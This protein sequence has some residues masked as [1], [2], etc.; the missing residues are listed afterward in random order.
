MKKVVAGL[1][2]GFAL[3]VMILVT[4]YND[5]KAQKPSLVNEN[6]AEQQISLSKKSDKPEWNWDSNEMLA[7]SVHLDGHHDIKEAL[8]EKKQSQIVNKL[9]E[10]DSEIARLFLALDDVKV[11]DTLD[12]QS[13]EALNERLS[14]FYMDHDIVNRINNG[15][16]NG[17]DRQAVSMLFAYTAKLRES[18]SEKNIAVLTSQVNQLQEDINSGEFPLPQ[19]LSL[20]QRQLIEQQVTENYQQRLLEREA[21]RKAEDEQLAEEEIAFLSGK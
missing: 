9:S 17:D 13:L 19:P 21:R 11:V 20:A 8:K 5:D 14:Q 3:L 7:E 15:G 18:I 16:V 2:C 6:D 1:F 12:H 10:L 4:F